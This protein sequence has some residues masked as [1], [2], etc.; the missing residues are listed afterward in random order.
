MMVLPYALIISIIAYFLN[1]KFVNEKKQIKIKKIFGL[2]SFIL[3]LLC[4]CSIAGLLEYNFNTRSIIRFAT[5][6][7]IPV[8]NYYILGKGVFITLSL[9]LLTLAY[10]FFASKIKAKKLVEETNKM[11]Y[12]IDSEPEEI[13]FWKKYQLLDILCYV[14]LSTITYIISSSFF[15]KF[16][17]FIIKTYL[18][19]NV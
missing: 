6:K 14:V 1:F 7:I 13:P 11:N 16:I 9:T 5:E 15:L 18:R 10:N 8:K 12:E 3:M 4:I 19:Y 17:A 2:L